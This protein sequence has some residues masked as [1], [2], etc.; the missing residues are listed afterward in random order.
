MTE[1]KPCVHCGEKMTAGVLCEECGGRS[2]PVRVLLDKALELMEGAEIPRPTRHD[3]YRFAR[4]EP[5][6]ML[7]AA[8]LVHHGEAA[9]L[10]EAIRAAEQ[11]G[12]ERSGR[13][14]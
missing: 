10:D 14:R 1:I 7:H 12:L 3:M 2:Y 11:F 5:G 4:L 9:T 8:A 13:P 6:P